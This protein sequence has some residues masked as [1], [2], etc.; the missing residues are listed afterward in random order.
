MVQVDGSALKGNQLRLAGINLSSQFPVVTSLV[1]FLCVLL[2][3][4]GIR[5]DDVI[6][7]DGFLSLVLKRIIERVLL[8]LLRGKYTA[9]LHVAAFLF[10]CQA[11]V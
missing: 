6:S 1:G 10:T 3:G 7:H 11:P 4:L 5:P 8:S 2:P 9:H